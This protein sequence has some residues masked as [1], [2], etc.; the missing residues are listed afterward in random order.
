MA[1][2]IPRIDKQRDRRTFFYSFFM[3][4]NQKGSGE[5]T[6][7]TNDNGVKSNASNARSAQ[8]CADE[9]T[10]GNAAQR[11]ATLTLPVNNPHGYVLFEDILMELFRMYEVEKNAKNEAYYFILSHGHFDAYR[12]YNRAHKGQDIDFH[13]ASVQCLY[14]MA[15][16][17]E[18]ETLKTA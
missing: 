16:E 4:I 8:N 18:R 2:Q 12:E 9:P 10:T 1:A 7:R 5:P 13:A 17:K 6:T 11:M 3:L 14:D 15:L